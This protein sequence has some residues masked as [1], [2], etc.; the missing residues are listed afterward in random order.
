M[1]NSP[2]TAA[3]AVVTSLYRLIHPDKRALQV[4]RGRCPST[5]KIRVITHL[6]ILAHLV[7]TGREVWLRGRAR[8]LLSEGRLF[9]SPGQHIKVSLDKILNPKTVL[10]STLP[11]S[12]PHQCMNG[13]MNY[14]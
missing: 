3:D 10:V 13:C 2:D 14:C 12:H 1:F 6:C 11:G 4:Q 5:L 7:G 9:D 8:L